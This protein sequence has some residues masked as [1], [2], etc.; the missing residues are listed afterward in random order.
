M[1]SVALF[2]DEDGKKL[3]AQRTVALPLWKDQQH[4][5]AIQSYGNALNCLHQWQGKL[6]AHGITNVLMVTDNSTLAGWIMEPSKNKKYTDY[7]SK[8]TYPYKLGSVKEITLSIGL[9]EPRESEKSHKY[10]REE[11]VVNKEML[12]GSTLKGQGNFG[13]ENKSS[14]DTELK[15]KTA[16][17]ILQ[18]DTPEGMSD[19]KELR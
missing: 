15:I 18:E 19:L 6:K 4:I 17:D 3:V 10:C 11:L 7:M 5:T 2:A 16:L 1:F 12:T 13:I 8:A 9:C 14:E